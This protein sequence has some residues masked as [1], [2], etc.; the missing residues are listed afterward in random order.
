MKAV[1]DRN[2]QESMED[3]NSFIALVVL[4]SYIDESRKDDDTC[5]TVFKPADL[6]Q[7]YSTWL[8]QLGAELYDHV[9]NICLKNHI[10]A[11]FPDL[12]THKEG[13]DVLWVFNKDL[14]AALHVYLDQNHHNEVIGQ[15]RAANTVRKDMLK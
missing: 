2:N 14:G 12:A 6:C 8:Q 1:H 5:I 15:S 10:L 7:L 4:L 3:I 11:H 9:H 13:Y